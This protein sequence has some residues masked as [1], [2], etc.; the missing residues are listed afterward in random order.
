MAKSEMSL[1]EN[2]F[3][4]EIFTV[5]AGWCRPGH[6]GNSEIFTCVIQNPGV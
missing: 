1:L 3:G 4:H 6:K 5:V 2:G